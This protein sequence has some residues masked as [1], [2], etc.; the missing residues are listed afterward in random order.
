[1]CRECG[2]KKKKYEQLTGESDVMGKSYEQFTA[3]CDGALLPTDRRQ[4][5]TCTD[6]YLSF[7]LGANSPCCPGW[8]CP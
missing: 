1:M 8:G 4:L 2:P 7:Y 3:A 6:V 5:Q